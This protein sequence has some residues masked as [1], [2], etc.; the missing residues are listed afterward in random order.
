MLTLRITASGV[1]TIDFLYENF[2]LKFR[3]VDFN[4]GLGV[5]FKMT[6]LPTF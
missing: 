5:L 3:N 4:N 2:F 6:P 1:K